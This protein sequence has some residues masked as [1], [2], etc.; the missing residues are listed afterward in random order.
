MIISKTQ[1]ATARSHLN[2]LLTSIQFRF[3]LSF[4]AFRALLAQALK[5]RQLPI[6]PLTA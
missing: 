1:S 3:H 5:I 4:R 2:L 6:L